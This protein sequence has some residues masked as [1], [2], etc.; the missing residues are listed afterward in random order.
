MERRGGG[1]ILAFDSGCGP[2]SKFKAVV[3]FLDARR[4]VGFLDIEEADRAGL[5]D[6]VPQALRFA[7]FHVVIEQD[8]AAGTRGV[9]SGSGAILPLVR[10]LSPSAS[11]LVGRVPVIEAALRFG[12]ST[13]SRLHTGCPASQ[14]QSRR[15]G[16]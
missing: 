9:A 11:R 15:E 14:R 7:S 8:A 16:R 12:Y 4:L 13:L 2:C 6:G 5:L 3:E 10:A 1:I